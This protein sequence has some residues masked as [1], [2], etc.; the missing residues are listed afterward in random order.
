G[1]ELFLEND[2]IITKL[3]IVEKKFNF[4]KKNIN[5]PNIFD[6]AKKYYN[7]MKKIY[8][9]KRY[10]WIINFLSKK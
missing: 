3:E 6:V 10:K 2:E 4:Y 9:Q 1:G 8:N 5:L 7:F